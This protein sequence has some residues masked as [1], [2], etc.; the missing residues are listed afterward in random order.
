MRSLLS[1]VSIAALLGGAACAGGSDNGGGTGG[2][3]AGGVGTGAGGGNG[4]S[5]AGTGGGGGGGGGGGNGGSSG[6]GGQ[7]GSSGAGG[8]GQGG[9]SG[10]GGSG[11]GG[12]GGAASALYKCPTGMTF[13]SPSAAVVNALS[14]QRVTGVPPADTFGQGFSILEGALWIDGTLYMS[15]IT[16]GNGPPPSRL[17]AYM[18]GGTATVLSADLG[19]NGMA[20]APN[21]DIVAAVHKDGSIRRFPPSDPTM[22]TVV[23]GMYMG[24][25]FDSP[26]DLAVRSDGNIY[27]SDPDYQA[28]STHPQ[29]ATRL[30]RV[31]PTGTLSVVDATLTE[32]NGV[33]LSLDENTMFVSGSGG[34][35]KFPLAAD[36]TP[37]TRAPNGSSSASLSGS[38]GMGIDCAG[39]LWVTT[40]ANVVVVDPSGTEIGRFALTGVDGATNIA[41]GGAD[42]KTVFIT[43]RGSTPGL[44]TV[45]SPLPGMPY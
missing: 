23:V 21:G 12:A 26:N 27:F 42:H 8:G 30:Y 5:T 28:P 36:G 40:N 4:G 14:P 10:A 31:S 41:F 24:A 11:A 6:S 33:T 34:V 32:P 13:T 38:D 20:V 1:L 18:P 16:G 2:S 7:G 45:A 44:F 17:L 37:G 29:T 39:D 22:Q 43:S 25:R 19:G 15:Q 9:S 3:G 35:F